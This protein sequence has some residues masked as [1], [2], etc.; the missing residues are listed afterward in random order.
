MAERHQKFSVISFTSN[1]E[2]GK[3]RGN[4]EKEKNAK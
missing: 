4:R 2:K 1:K 3:R